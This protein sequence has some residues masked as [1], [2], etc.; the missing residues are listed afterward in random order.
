MAVTLTPARVVDV[1]DVVGRLTRAYPMANP[2]KISA[3]ALAP[4]F[5][6][7]RTATTEIRA[8]YDRTFKWGVVEGNLPD[9]ARMTLQQIETEL[10]RW[11]S[12]LLNYEKNL[13]ICAQMPAD[14]ACTLWPIVAPLFF[15]Y[16]GGATSTEPQRAPDIGRPFIVANQLAELRRWSED[17]LGWT[18]GVRD[19]EESARNVAG[20][21]SDTVVGT[22]RAMGQAAG[23]VAGG[24]LEGLGP[25]LVIVG[26]VVLW[27]M[28]RRRKGGGESGGL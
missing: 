2:P 26:A 15:G 16:F 1:G 18:A 21:V 7:L 17:Q 19:L 6:W 5:A 3:D 13:A 4:L 8:Q 10:D 9:H 12:D 11:E 27:L 14:P 20:V 24:A 25:V 22:F 23:A 28:F